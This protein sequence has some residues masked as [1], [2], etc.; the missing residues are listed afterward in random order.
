MKIISIILC[1]IILGCSNGDR[2]IEVEYS[3]TITFKD[4]KQIVLNRQVGLSLIESGNYE[5]ALPHL[6]DALQLPEVKPFALLNQA[7]CMAGLGRCHEADSLAYEAFS[8]GIKW[9]WVE[10]EHFSSCQMEGI[11]AAHKRGE[12]AYRN[13]LDTCLL[14]SIRQMMEY[15]QKYR[16][17]SGYS[18]AHPTFVNQEIIDT[19]NTE[20]LKMII[21]EYGWPSAPETG[22]EITQVHIIANHA[23]EEDLYYFLEK[24]WDAAQKGRAPWPD[25]QSIMSMTLFRFHDDYGMNK[26]RFV[27]ADKEGNLD[28]EASYFQLATLAKLTN[29]NPYPI[30]LLTTYI[31]EEELNIKEVRIRNLYQIREELVRLGVPATMITIEEEMI[32]V[33]PDQISNSK[34]AFTR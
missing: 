14:S 34:F 31:D 20:K 10:T 27:H 18:K 19:D 1:F 17:V 8:R 22:V 11:K 13:A 12:V 7:Y 9:E 30:R 6:T 4:Y 23:E 2:I 28:T 5:Q 15:D 26:L 16:S 32:K 25:V 24:A 29:R 3:P 33:L 21:E